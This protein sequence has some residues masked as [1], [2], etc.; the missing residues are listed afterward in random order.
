[1]IVDV[2]TQS[3]ENAPVEYLHLTV[4]LRVVRRC[5]RVVNIQ[6]PTKIEEELGCGLFSV[7]SDGISRW[8][9]VA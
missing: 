7:F 1:M 5:E 6:D 3:G 2:R 9:F 8:V 4:R